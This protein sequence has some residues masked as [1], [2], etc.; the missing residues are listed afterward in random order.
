MRQL[1]NF[2]RSQLQA[3]VVPLYPRRLNQCIYFAL[4]V[5]VIR[6]KA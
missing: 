4:R 2:E 6:V 5:R 1:G 3:L